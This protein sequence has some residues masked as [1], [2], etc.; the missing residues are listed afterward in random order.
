MITLLD[1]IRI[2]TKMAEEERKM[3]NRTC[4]E[5]D[6][7][8]SNLTVGE[9]KKI[10]EDL[11]DDIPIVTT[12]HPEDDVNAVTGYR[13][14]RTVGALSCKSE[15][16]QDVLCLAPAWDGADMAALVNRRFCDSEVFCKKVYF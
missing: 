2:H 3:W 14:I 13:F 1:L 16:H 8:P 5:K 12:N 7:K 10:L 6:K 11:P 15:E 4:M 9:L